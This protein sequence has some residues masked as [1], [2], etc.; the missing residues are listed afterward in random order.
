[1]VEKEIITATVEEAMVIVAAMA[2]EVDYGVW[3]NAG[4]DDDGGNG[5]NGCI[6]P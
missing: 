2:M 1:M 5:G 6:D 3:N 4:D